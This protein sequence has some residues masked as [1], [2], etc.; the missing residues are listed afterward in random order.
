M[1]G[2][3]LRGGLIYDGTGT[4]AYSADVLVREGKIQQIGKGLAAEQVLE[5]NAE[6]CIVTPGFLDTHRHC[7]I[8]PMRDKNFGEIELAQGIT[9]T[10]V[11]NCGLAPV[12][13]D[14]LQHAEFYEYIEPVVG[15][16]L[17]SVNTSEYKE[18][19]KALEQSNLLLNMGFLAGM[20]AVRYA[21]KGFSSQPFTVTEQEKAQKLLEQ[22]M[23]SGALGVSLGIMYRPECYTSAQEYDALIQPVV[24]KNGLL[25]T[26]IRGEGDNL[27]PSV[28]EVIGIAQRTGARLN[29]SH[30]KATGLRN[31]RDK[32]FRAM[33][34]ISEARARGQEVTADFYP[35]D[36][37]STTLLSLLPPVLMEKEQKFFATPQGRERLKT[38][39]Y[40]EH[41]GW[42][43]MVLSIGWARVLLSGVKGVRYATCQ[44]MT[45]EAAAQKNGYADPADFMAELIAEE[46]AGA[47]IIVLSM[48]WR[49]VEEVASLPYTALISD[50][51][52]GGAGNPHPRL[53]GAFP[54]MLQKFVLEKQIMPME[55]A[56]H[57]MT[58]MPA[59]RFGLNDRGI[60]RPGAKADLLV[61]RPEAFF[62]TATYT[63]PCSFAKGLDHAF[64]NGKHVWSNGTFSP[65]AIGGRL[66]RREE[67]K[68]ESECY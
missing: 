68:M 63:A 13:L 8:A 12:P 55:Q 26:H 7:D 18:Y 40:R 54:R 67:S 16:A 4:P 39:I 48:D 59:Q 21:V 56:I 2:F 10:V 62:D 38:E 41:A 31:W 28:Q 66:L 52:Y 45:F 53:Y 65:N 35:Y 44:G 42:D 11:G 46:G 43:N 19:T 22:A 47:G 64:V 1:N 29:I 60:L 27:L 14:P 15:P 24:R 50:A 17:Q 32:I 33:E 49:D 9:S 23:D 61:F 57:K 58:G 30:F 3:I 37:G 51:L 36:G 34:C 6:G 5:L 25:C 20:G